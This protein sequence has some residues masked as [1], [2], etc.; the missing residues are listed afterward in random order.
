MESICCVHMRALRQDQDQE[1]SFLRTLETSWT[2][3]MLQVL[4]APIVLLE[5]HTHITWGNWVS[6]SLYDQRNSTKTSLSTEE[7]VTYVQ[8]STQ[9]YKT[10][11][12]QTHEIGF[13]YAF[14]LRKILPRPRFP[15][16]LD[17]LFSSARSL[18]KSVSPPS[19][20]LNKN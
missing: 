20:M 7:T 17:L 19:Y 12:R 9:E 10:Q 4:L 11:P 1:L 15:F 6:L 8:N 3:N 13:T 16:L 5:F 2:Q 18:E 14:D